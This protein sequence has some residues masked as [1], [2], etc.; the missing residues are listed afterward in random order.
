MEKL[1]LNT[2]IVVDENGCVTTLTDV[3][4]KGCDLDLLTI[5]LKVAKQNEGNYQKKVDSY[6][7]SKGLKPF[8]ENPD[9]PAE[10]SDDDKN[11]EGSGETSEHHD[12]N[13]TE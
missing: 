1:E 2:K 9:A 8:G 10:I 12:N 13:I 5:L 3:D 7:I 11:Q 6:R 4:G